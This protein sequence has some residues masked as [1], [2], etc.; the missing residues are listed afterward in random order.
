MDTYSADPNHAVKDAVM[1]AGAKC[2]RG[3]RK[4]EPVNSGCETWGSLREV[5]GH[6]RTVTG[7]ADSWRG[8]PP[9]QPLPVLMLCQLAPVSSLSPSHASGVP[10]GLCTCFMPRPK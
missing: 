6:P 4:R 3:T 5:H 8:G 7:G 2:W 1:G 10:Q 9:L